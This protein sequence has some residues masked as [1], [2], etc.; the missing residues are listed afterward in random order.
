MYRLS[1]I[2]TCQWPHTICNETTCSLYLII[3]I[4]FAERHRQLHT[5]EAER[6]RQ[7]CETITAIRQLSPLFQGRIRRVTGVTS[8]P[9]PER[10][11][12][13]LQRILHLKLHC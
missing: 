6:R 5:A 2:K 13:I 1:D 12:V 10:E 11:K 4:L 3:E 7:K 8:R 9:L